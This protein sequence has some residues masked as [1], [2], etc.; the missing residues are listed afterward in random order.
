MLFWPIVIALGPGFVALYYD[1]DVKSFAD[2]S[3][4]ER[5]HPELEQRARQAKEFV[6]ALRVRSHCSW[7]ASTRRRRNSSR[8]WKSGDKT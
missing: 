2:Q 4:C 3:V 5:T 1:H 7:P 8:T 6:T